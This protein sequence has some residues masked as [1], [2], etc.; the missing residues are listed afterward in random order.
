MRIYGYIKGISLRNG[1][2]VDLCR[3]SSGFMGGSGGFGHRNGGNSGISGPKW[4][5]SCLFMAAQGLDEGAGAGGGLPMV[6][7]PHFACHGQ[8]FWQC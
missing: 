6:L 1:R 5:V 8:G 3:V 7:G 4:V 2:F